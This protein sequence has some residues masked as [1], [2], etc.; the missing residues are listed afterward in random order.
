MIHQ[1][2]TGILSS[3][4]FFALGTYVLII[5]KSIVFSSV[6][7]AVIMGGLGAI[8]G[9]IMGHF[10]GKV[11]EAPPKSTRTTEDLFQETDSDLLIDNVMIN[12]LKNIDDNDL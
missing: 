12:E 8:I 3:G 1:K 4:T 11:I 7:K 6:L 10:I 5:E 9:A 2:L